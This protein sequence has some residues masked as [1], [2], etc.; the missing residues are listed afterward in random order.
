[1]KTIEEVLKKLLTSVVLDGTVYFDE[2]GNI[3][4]DCTAAVRGWQIQQDGTWEEIDLL[5][6]D[7]GRRN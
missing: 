4:R 5:T 1:M 7:R 3:T 2:H 6:S